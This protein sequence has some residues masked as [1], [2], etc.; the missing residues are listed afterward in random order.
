MSEINKQPK[1]LDG[2]QPART[3]SQF[4]STWNVERFVVWVVCLSAR[5]KIRLEE[6]SLLA[7]PKYVL[8]GCL[9]LTTDNMQCD[10][11]YVG[12]AKRWFW[13]WKIMVWVIMLWQ[14]SWI[15]LIF[16]FFYITQPQLE[17]ET[18]PIGGG[19]IKPHNH[20]HKSL[21]MKLKERCV[22]CYITQLYFI[23]HMVFIEIIKTWDSPASMFWC[24]LYNL[25][26]GNAISSEN[27]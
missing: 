4:F 21:I 22:F 24:C 14:Q 20:I 6:Y 9:E 18:Q 1:W 5:L 8:F 2:R 19:G 10:S 26:L 7:V 16:F 27:A 15:F 3:S 25:F 11:Q 17:K 23:T 13:R 12:W